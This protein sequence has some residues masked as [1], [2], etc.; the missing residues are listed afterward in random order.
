[1]EPSKTPE[2]FLK[3]YNPNEQEPR[4]LDLW[5]RSGYA[6]PDVCIEKGVTK[7]DAEA[8]SIV[9]PP[10]NVT[11]IL[12]MGSALMVVIE[13]ILVRYTRMRGKRTLWIPGTDSA[14]IATQSR[15]EKDIQKTEKKSRHDLGR[16]ELLR[17]IEIFVEE[18]KDV[19]VNQ[20]K[21]M[22]ASL[23]W[24]RY[25]YTM[26]EKRY[27]AVM[28]AFVQMYDAGLIYRGN[29]IVNWDPKGQTTISDDEIVYE[30]RAAKLVTFKYSEEFPISVA[31]TRLETKVGDTAVAVHPDD[32][33]YR[34]FVNKEYDAV[35][36][37]VPI[38]LKIVADESVDPAF[39]TGA[40]GVTP[41]HSH[42]DWEIADR[43]DLQRPQVIDE[44]ARMTVEGPLRSKKTTEARAMI[45]E[46]LQKENLLIK[47]E[48]IQQ[49]VATAER[50]G[51]IVEPLPKLQWFVNVNK[52]IAG[53]NGKS[54]KELMRESVSR[55]GIKILPQHFEKVYFNWIDNLRDWCISRQIWFGHR[56]PVWYHEPKCIPKPGREADVEKCIEMKVSIEKPVCEFCDAKYVQDPD[57]LDTWFSSGLWTF[58]TLGWPEE[59]ADLKTYH[60][61]SVLETGYDI[62]FFWV[63]R[64]ILMSGFLLGDIPF[65]TVYLHGIV[66]DG[67]GRKISKSLGNN[68]DPLDMAAKYG[69]DAV[70]MSLI[71]GMAPG[72]DSRI[73][74]EK[75]RGYKHFA[76]K[77]WNITRFV[78]ENRND[79]DTVS[80]ID[81]KLVA[82]ANE[83]ARQV[84]DNINKFRLDLAADSVYHFVWDR[85]AA[86]I[87]EQSKSVLKGENAPAR[88]SR[89]RALHEILLI[90]LKLL[91]PFMPFVTEAIWQQLPQPASA[92]GSGEARKDSDLLMV[93]KW[94][95]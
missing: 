82:E 72:T 65:R 22:G 45:L 52:P 50:T 23:D 92:Q 17:R 85:F 51:G 6:N 91:H 90:S 48:E 43:Y 59:T 78:L 73:S 16:D 35:F 38:H 5:E 57:T 93:A 34:A 12:H 83:V 84:S 36:C 87:I 7:S 27:A 28:A 56:I 95:V 2:Q 70:R 94:P 4:I 32:A 33:R 75:I 42:V 49:N 64:M 3:P 81:E 80:T 47:E 29:R 79:G 53:R 37:G 24:S 31:T 30:E 77:I 46:W 15:V 39:G 68:I 10:P 20:F 21:R 19:I 89:A 88:A 40:L 11:G 61:T 69:M 26:D 13:D 25:A 44:H 60:P 55:G 76:N 86:E 9:L 41:A 67:R 18:N 1:M 62:L 58:S 66:R 74:E 71:A 14:A 8:Y 54:L 63:A